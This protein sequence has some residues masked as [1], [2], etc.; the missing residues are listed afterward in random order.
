MVDANVLYETWQIVVFTN[1]NNCHNSIVLVY[2]TVV[3]V[4][5]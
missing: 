3:I 2:L 4:R 5:E 1:D